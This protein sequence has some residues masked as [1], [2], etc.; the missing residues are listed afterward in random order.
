MASSEHLFPT[1]T[2]AQ[3]ARVAAHGR[4]RATSRGEVLTDVGTRNVPLFVVVSGELEVLR[5]SGGADTLITTHRAGQFSG[6]ANMITGRPSL[7][8]VRVS[9]SGELIEVEREQVLRLI[10]NDA[11]LSAIFMRAFILRRSELIAGEVGD[12]VVIGSAHCAGTLR[13]KEFLTRNGHPFHAIDLDRDAAAQA[14]LDKF[15]ISA[16]DVP[17]VICGGTTVLRRPTNREIADCLGFNESV[18]PAAMR[19]LV[20]VG[21]GPAGL[22]AA[23]YGASEGLDVLVVE[24]GSPGGQAGMSS[25]IENYLGFPNGVSGLELTSRAYAQAQ[26]FGAQILIA[27]GAMK[28]ACDRTPYSLE[29]DGGGRVAARALII[30]TGAEYRRP[31]LENLS[32]F[33]G[34]GVYYSATQMEAQLCVGEE[35]IIVGGANSAGQ[36]AIFL[37][38]TARRVQMFVRHELSETMSKYLIQR[39]EDNAERIRVRTH[40]EIVGLEGDRQLARVRWRNSRTGEKGIEDVAHVFMM[41]GASPNTGWLNGC[42]VLDEKGFIK[43]GADL[44]PEDLAAARWPL[45]R[46]PYLLETSRP[47]VF[48]V[49]DVRAHNVKRVASAV[50]EGSIAV[51][52]VHQVLQKS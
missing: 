9:E 45:K 15:R 24:A 31:P 19:D 27:Q 33:E 34:A 47:G 11:E 1:L 32:R 23:V 42:V 36:A 41:T 20:V 13:V 51:S 46:P 43:T 2:S 50:G 21:A 7:S 18:D 49:G 12:V 28:V 26:K 8:R 39:I 17:V 44:T 4:R 14:M 3:L 29:I 37:A 10:Q 16:G 25:R 35:V 6:E 48:A 30:A 52:F 22:A 40:T 38:D 5:T